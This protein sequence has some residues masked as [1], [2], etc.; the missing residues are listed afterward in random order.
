MAQG[1]WRRG[2]RESTRGLIGL[3]SRQFK[4]KQCGIPHC[5][6]V[7]AAVASHFQLREAKIGYNLANPELPHAGKPRDN[8][9]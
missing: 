8:T 6:F 2:R 3:T 1:K 9:L 4:R 5:F 7:V